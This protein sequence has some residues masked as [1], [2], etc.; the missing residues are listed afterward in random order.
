MFGLRIFAG[1]RG[2]TPPS[3]YKHNLRCTAFADEKWNGFQTAINALTI[4]IFPLAVVVQMAA[5]IDSVAG[6]N[7]LLA[8]FAMLIARGL[9]F[10]GLSATV[11]LA[12]DDTEN[13]VAA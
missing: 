13:A 5:D 10:L 1:Y 4:A 3:L 7:A 2:R 9:I 12:D 8:L 6:W 11:E